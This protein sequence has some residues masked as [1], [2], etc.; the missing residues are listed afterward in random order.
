MVEKLKWALGEKMPSLKYLKLQ[1][2]VKLDKQQR[3][4][5]HV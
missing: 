5:R 4:M 3:A 1:N 2:G